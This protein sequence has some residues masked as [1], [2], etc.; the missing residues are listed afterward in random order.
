[1]VRAWKVAIQATCGDGSQET[2]V[3]KS[4]EAG[5]RQQVR[6]ELRK[7]MLAM[8]YT[9]KSKHSLL[10]H[11]VRDQAP[12][13]D[14]A[15]RAFHLGPTTQRGSSRRCNRH[16]S[17]IALATTEQEYWMSTPALLVLFL[18]WHSHRRAKRDKRAIEQT[19]EAMFAKVLDVGFAQAL[20]IHEAPSDLGSHCDIDSRDARCW[21][22]RGVLSVV[23]KVD[24][25]HAYSAIFTCLLELHHA[26]Q[27]AVCFAWLSRLLSEVATCIDARADVWGDSNLTEN[28]DLI[29]TGVSATKRRR[30]DEHVKLLVASTPGQTPAEVVRAKGLAHRTTPCQWRA[31][32]LSE[33]RCTSMLR[34]QS[35]RSA[36]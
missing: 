5:D 29:D 25:E 31:K 32:W 23:A 7:V 15:L 9:D 17:V 28:Q 35:T 33:M 24:H 2:C 19:V 20:P 4:W 1:M 27:C 14:D 12:R 36:L 11:L 8:G 16:R 34:A 10:C 6:W 22:V 26:R 18:W 13:W 21:C 3:L 30:V